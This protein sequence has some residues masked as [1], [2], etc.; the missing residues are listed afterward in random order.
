MN[1]DSYLFNYLDFVYFI[2][3]NCLVN[4]RWLCLFDWGKW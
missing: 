1:P 3:D 2:V 4:E